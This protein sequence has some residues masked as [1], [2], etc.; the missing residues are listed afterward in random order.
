[1]RPIG[2]LDSGAETFWA[3]PTT[4]CAIGFV[5]RGAYPLSQI[6]NSALEATNFALLIDE[7]RGYGNIPFFVAHGWI[8]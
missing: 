3:K 4:E 2:D 8:S 1:M 7:E 6:V 5:S